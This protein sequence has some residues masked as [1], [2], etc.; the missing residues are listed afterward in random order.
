MKNRSL[1]IAVSSVG[2]GVLVLAGCSSPMAVK[3]TRHSGSGITS[4]LHE[5][6]AA[7]DNV[8]ARQADVETRDGVV[9]STGVGETEEARRKAG[10]YLPAW[11]RHWITP[12]MNEGG[13]RDWSA[14]SGRKASSERNPTPKRGTG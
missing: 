7:N 3:A 11:L 9:Y 10:A 13:D 5:S 1:V 4:V 8:E 14:I 6:L 12:G 2:L